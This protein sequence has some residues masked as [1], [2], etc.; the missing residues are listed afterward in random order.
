MLAVITGA[1]GHLGANLIRALADR[2]WRVRALV[3]HDARALEGVDV[4]RINGDVLDEESLKRAFTGAD[5]VFHLAAYV[6][7]VKWERKEVEAVNITGVQNVVN[8]CLA[9]GVKRLIHTSSFH[10]LKQEPLDQP[11]DESRPLFEAGDYPPYN[12][13]KA[14]GEKIVLKAMAQGLDAVIINPTGILGP[15][16]Y[17]PSHFGATILSI[18]KGRFPFLVNAGLNWVDSR[19]VAEGMIRACELAKAGSKYLLGGHWV[20]LKDIAQKVTKI[21]GAP[22][23]RVMLPMWIAK[24]GA[25]PMSLFYRITGK[26]P[27]FTPISIKELE[28][29]ANISYE[30]A[31]SELGYE[32]RPIEQTI[33]DTIEWFRSHGYLNGYH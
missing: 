15:Y 4:E 28:S 7:I 20:T 5:M 23:P 18:A 29:N 3:R 11:L 17:K 12:Y 32:P 6:S 27:L 2:R 19:D 33:T 25:P 31:S 10:A 14:K 13:S 21:T 26:R 9:V 1:S 30:K 16:D 24:A 22:V 8:A